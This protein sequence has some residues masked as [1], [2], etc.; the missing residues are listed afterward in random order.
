MPFGSR[1]SSVLRS[2]LRSPAAR[3]AARDLGRSAIDALQDSRRGGGSGGDTGSTGRSST[4]TRREGG[5]SAD[6]RAGSGAGG[7]ADV[8]ADRSTSSPVTMT[9]APHPD[10]VPD[11]GEVVWAWV[12]YEESL[13]QGKDRP[14][15]VIALED[16]ADGGADG[17][18]PTLVALMLT[19]KDRVGSG[20]TSRDEHGNLWVDVGTGDWDS[21][22]RASEV[23]ADRLLRIAPAAVRRADGRLPA[24]A[25]ERVA[26]AVRSAHGWG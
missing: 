12:H 26:A 21:Q 18:G 7:N 20:D 22:G 10:D 6:G 1:L 25:F 24:E 23:R 13:E 19:S 17:S 5:E 3:R 15:L 8:L 16:A 2:V 9:Y 4:T 14:V 11:P